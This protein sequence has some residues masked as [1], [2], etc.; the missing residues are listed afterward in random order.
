MRCRPLLNIVPEAAHSGLALH[1]TG[2]RDSVARAA[3][4]TVGCMGDLG[5]VR[6]ALAPWVSVLRAAA[7]WGGAAACLVAL[8]LNRA[9]PQLPSTDVCLLPVLLVPPPFGN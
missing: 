4:A 8:R 2:L 1:G 3:A 9:L 7:F 6:V 5:G